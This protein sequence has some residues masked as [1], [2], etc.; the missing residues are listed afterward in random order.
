VTIVLIVLGCGCSAGSGGDRVDSGGAEA[1]VGGSGGIGGGGGTSR[2]IDVLFVIDDSGLMT[3]GQATFLASV[4]TFFDALAGL[5]GGLPDLHVAV[6]T[7]DMGAGDGSS[8]AFCSAEGDD[9]VFRFA[10]SG[11]CAASGLDAGATFLVDSGGANAETNFGNQ[12][13]KTAFQC[14]ADLGVE[15]C[16]FQMPLAAAARALGADG[17]AAPSENAGF[18]REDAVLAIVLLSKEDDCSA[19]RGSPLFNPTSVTLSSTY[20]PTA[21]F[22]CNE[23]VTSAC[24]RA[25]G[26]RRDRRGLRRT[27]SRPTPSRTRQRAVPTTAYLPR[28]RGSCSRSPPAESPT[29]SR[30]SSLTLRGRSSWW[31]SR[32]PPPPTPY[33]G[34]ARRPGTTSCGR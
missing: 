11:T 23:W 26:P 28:G 5:P 30:V 21:H 12:D 29:G 6:T 3:A 17:V 7:A 4:G 22:L 9:G 33:I 18:L 24:R 31:R 34:R 10:A 15:G 16:G 1:G 19:P 20:G 13:L 32:G 14:I 27:T 8:I 2:Q 25:V